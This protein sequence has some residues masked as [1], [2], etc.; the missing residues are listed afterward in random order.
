MSIKGC[1]DAAVNQG[2]MT[3]EE[4]EAIDE[5]FQRYSQGGRGDPFA[6]R[7]QLV[8]SLRKNAETKRLIGA[9]QAKKSEELLSFI[10]SVRSIKGLRDPVAFLE[11]ILEHHGGFKFQDVSHREKELM[12]L[13]QARMEGMLHHFRKGFITGDKRRSSKFAK[14]SA[15]LKADLEAFVKEAFGENSNNEM[16]KE[17]A[18]AFM[19]TADL[20][21]TLYNG[22]AGHSAI[23]KLEWTRWGLSQ[24]HDSQKIGK[25]RKEDW[26]AE[27]K[28]L[29]DKQKMRHWGGRN[30]GPMLEE[31][32]DAYLGKVY[33]HIKSGGASSREAGSL[34]HGQSA[35]Y[36]DMAD[37]RFLHFKD[38]ASWM[39]YN[40]KYGVGDAYETVVSYFA[41]MSRDIALMDVLGPNP[42][43]T[44]KW[45]KSYI[46]DNYDNGTYGRGTVTTR[47]AQMDDIAGNLEKTLPSLKNKPRATAIIKEL[48]ELHKKLDKMRKPKLRAT[49]KAIEAHEARMKALK[50]QS[51][52][53]E[54]EFRGLV[55]ETQDGIV[56][57]VEVD[58]QIR[59]YFD[60]LHRFDDIPFDKLRN[61][62]WGESSLAARIKL[63]ESM[64]EVQSEA[65]DPNSIKALASVGQITRNLI[66]ASSL[67]SAVISA[68]S[69]HSFGV[70]A[71]HFSG[72]KTK[73][74]LNDFVKLISTQN[75]REM[76][77]SEMI[78][79]NA[80]RALHIEARNGLAIDTKGWSGFL[81]DRVIDITGLAGWTQVAKHAF[82]WEFMGTM[83]D[84]VGKR[85]DQLDPK[86]QR[87]FERH[88]I[89]VADW[90][91]IRKADVYNLEG[92]EFLRSNEIR[93]IDPELATKFHSMII[94]ERAYAVPEAT[95]RTRAIGTGGQ[96]AG[97]VWGEAARSMALFKSFGMSV[98]IMQASRMM[99]EAYGHGAMRGAQYAMGIFA[100][101]TMLGGLA[102]QLKEMKKGRT[103]RDMGPGFW[104]AAMYQGGGMGLLGDTFQSFGT[105]RFGGSPLD[106]LLGPVYGR[107]EKLAKGVSEL[108][109]EGSGGKLLKETGRLMP[110]SN[111]WF[112]EAGWNRFV[113]DNISRL[114][115]GDKKHRRA[116]KRHLKQQKK[117]FGNDYWWGPQ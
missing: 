46:K 103:P 34:V 53:L 69:D 21:R 62:K 41:T 84:N 58:A 111:A 13:F 16:A 106:S 6:A 97:T 37:P 96:G 115:D 42:H 2:R 82:S 72:L 105:N 78:L 116:V 71:R 43:R 54:E 9:Q 31:E 75:R 90:N 67:G 91:K 20:A 38:A 28:E 26:I 17:F 110:G 51:K 22:A 25:V 114:A 27:T 55:D 70:M 108:V 57:A 48:S 76:V 44:F 102:L 101:T 107:G 56:K 50:D 92:A 77:R 86:I 112:L 24:S 45:L 15:A 66:T 80:I 95:L 5:K 10:N 100:M 81:A 29:L 1:L 117:N 59:S 36:K 94:R 93:N 113:V 39:E 11:K 32:L 85:F 7:D 79:D 40:K 109:T 47:A 63:A 8:N 12:G 64:F 83:A 23:G 30:A 61:N 104:M 49:K 73:R 98:F 18:K 88:N 3:R 35:L 87:L 99:R 33:D 52:V 74:Q 89:S 19:E 14:E 4:A 60:D 65:F 68:V